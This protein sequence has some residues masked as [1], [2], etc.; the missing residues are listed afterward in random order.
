MHNQ[1]LEKLLIS[2]CISGKRDAQYRLYK[3][4]C[5]AMYNICLR[6]INDHDDAD[7]VLQNAFID[8]F[9][10]LKMFKYESTIGAWIKRIVI[11]NCINHLRKNKVVV[12]SFD[13]QLDIIDDSWD[14]D[15]VQLDISGVKRAISLLPDGYRIIF[16]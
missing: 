2:D 14:K 7:D 11:N 4:Y 13:N 10:K 16:S 5:K 6:I 8:V 1:E 3:T 15:D 12:Q 9:S